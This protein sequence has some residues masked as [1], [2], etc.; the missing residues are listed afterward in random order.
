MSVHFPK[1][2]LVDDDPTWLMYV[3]LLTHDK[4]MVCQDS[5]QA[6]ELMR[7]HTIQLLITDT[8]MPKF[9]GIDL[10]KQVRAEFPYLP[11]IVLFSGLNGTSMTREE[12]LKAGATVVMT[13]EEFITH[14]DMVLPKPD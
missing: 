7:E 4:L 11:V 9:S 14:I 5:T 13:K 1:T 12:V 10:L 8:N 2:L 3:Q 6:M